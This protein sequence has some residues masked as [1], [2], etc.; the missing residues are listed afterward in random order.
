[1]GKGKREKIELALQS[2]RKVRL[3]AIPTQPCAKHDLGLL[4][5]PATKSEDLERRFDCIS[6]EDDAS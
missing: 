4:S 1:M 6:N 2:Q 3:S 5:M